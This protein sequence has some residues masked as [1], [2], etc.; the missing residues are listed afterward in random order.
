MSFVR[1][2]KKAEVALSCQT[3][4]ICMRFAR[5]CWWTVTT[6]AASGRN[7]SS[8]SSSRMKVFRNSEEVLRR[9]LTETQTIA[10]VGAS[11]KP[12]RPSNEVLGILLRAGYK[13]IPVNPG[14]EGEEI[15]G[16]RVYATL[17]DIPFPIDMVDIFRRSED[18]GKIVD[19][20][21]ELNVRSVWMQI[22]VID[23][24]AAMR[25][26]NAGLDVAM[27]VCPARE[28]PRLRI[29]GPKN[30]SNL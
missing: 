2:D 7:S 16:Q 10:L 22:G 21:I 29:S 4:V 6:L 19:E 5:A 11:K 15:H 20:A 25:A 14:H 26:Q 30:V 24:A 27:D 8:S 23:E 28:L 12:H 18:A 9:I 1:K 17:A 3:S 13:V